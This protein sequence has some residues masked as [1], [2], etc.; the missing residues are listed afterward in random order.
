[1]ENKEIKSINDLNREFLEDYISKLPKEEK[2][3]MREYLNNHPQKNA[4]GNGS[5]W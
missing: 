4:A 2:E 5:S 1:M 3:K